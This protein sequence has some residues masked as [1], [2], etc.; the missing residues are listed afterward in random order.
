MKNVFYIVIISLGLFSCTSKIENTSTPVTDTT[1]TNINYADGFRVSEYKGFKLVDVVYPYQGATSGYKYLLIPRGATVPEHPADYKIIYTPL[2]SIACTSTTHIPLLDYLNETDKLT[3]F[4]T[5]DYISSEKMRARVDAGKVQELG[6]DSGINIELLTV[7]KPD[8]VMAYT[9]SSDYG[10]FK[11]IEALGIPVVINAEYLEKHPLGR[12]EW[13]KFMALFFNKE[14]T[15]DSVF[16]IVESNYR[17]IQK[18][19]AQVQ[20]RPSVLSGIVYGDTWFLPGGQNYAS[21]ILDDAGCHYLW[22][23]D[24]SHGYLELSFESVYDK[25]HN[26]NLWIGVGNIKSLQELEQADHR[27]K[28]FNPFGAKQV[29]TYD[30]KKGAKGGSE[31]LELGYLRPDIIL[32]DLVAIAHPDLLPNDTL[33]FHKRLE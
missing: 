12:A 27:Y 10:Q 5:T 13:I 24:S 15:A 4:T 8:A 7:L 23:S 18:Q 1:R 28:K 16:Q 17:R 6:K 22:E 29:Y 19:A 32:S 3:G 25:A 14:K 9:M 30:G 26:A 11:K 20:T 31:F 21:K 33:Y 2:T